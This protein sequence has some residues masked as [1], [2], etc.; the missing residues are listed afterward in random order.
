MSIFTNLRRNKKDM[1]GFT[2][3]ELLV[4][5]AIIGTLATLLLLQ[6]GVA[7]AK[8]RDAKRV[9]DINQLRSAAELYFDDNNAH[10]PVALDIASIGKYL[11]A[12]AV[13]LDPVT[14]VG[15]FYAFDPAVNPL[16]FHLWTELEGKSNG[17]TGDSDLDSSTWAGGGT[18][19]IDASLAATEVCTAAYAAGAARDCIY[20]TG[21]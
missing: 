16:R 19:R 2:L 6:L 11:S 5:I 10:Y 20:D 7:R 9:A 1:G 14:A 13:P 15:Y 17:L 21:Q 8:A 18:S 12:P 4:V 3:V